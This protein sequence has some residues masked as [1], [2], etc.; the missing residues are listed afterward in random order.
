MMMAW[1]VKTQGSYSDD[2]D[3]G[4][5]PEATRGECSRLHTPGHIMF[6]LETRFDF[7]H[8]AADPFSPSPLHDILIL[9]VPSFPLLLFPLF[10][11]LPQFLFLIM[12]LLLFLP[13]ASPHTPPSPPPASHTP[14]ELPASPGLS[15]PSPLRGRS[16]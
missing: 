2:G 7:L 3:T 11:L 8:S 4:A 10:L 1:V 6:R 9:P 5:T 12:F 16:L 14:P 13:H 15:T